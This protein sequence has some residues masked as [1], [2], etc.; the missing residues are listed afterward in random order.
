MST[1]MAI[2]RR[3]FLA[4][5][6]AGGTALAFDASVV[7]AAARADAPAQILNAFVRINADNTVTIGAKNPEIGQGVKVMLPMLI[8][9]EM[10]LAW[11]QVRIEQTDADEKRFGVQT[12]GGS[13]ATPRNWLPMRQVGA[14]AR[15]MLINAAAGTWGV[16]AD[17]LSTTRGTVV[18]K[19][20]GKSDT[21]AALAK[22]AAAV[23]APDL[24]SVTLKD[25][26]TFSIIGTSKPGVDVAKI[27][28]GEPLFGID[29]RL[30]GLL[31]GAMIKCPAHGGTIASFDDT[32]AKA[33]PGVT[34]V[35][36]VN[37]GFVPEG[38]SDT[39][40]VVADS[41]WKASKAREKIA[42]TWDDDAV[43]GFSTAGYEAQAAKVLAGDAQTSAFKAGDADGALAK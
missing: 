12:A 28:Q 4:A 38:K 43:T 41:W 18:H 35:V 10:D 7:L 1:A 32:A 42:V 3:S 13:T 34:A 39:I 15:I 14:A 29:T 19:A 26:K 5:S 6:L 9:E 16:S 11:E 27:V 2:N 25:A 21:Y 8:A 30:P 24:A 40:V 31:H 37:S 22:A 33:I 20:S 36:A 17:S 23:P